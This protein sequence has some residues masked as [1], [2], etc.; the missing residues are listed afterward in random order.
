MEVNYFQIFL[1]DVTFY[2]SLTSLKDGT[3]R[4]NKKNEKPSIIVTGRERVKSPLITKTLMLW[5]D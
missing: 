4:A 1:V 3:Q 2:L 5:Y